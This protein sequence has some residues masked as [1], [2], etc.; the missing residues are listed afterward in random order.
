MRIKC[1][2]ILWVA[3]TVTLSANVVTN[4]S[5]ETGSFTNTSQNYDQLSAGSGAITGW[6]VITNSV[7]WGL[8]LTDGSARNGNG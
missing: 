5:F 7:A 2:G 3:A 1:L 6:T 8:N 4:G